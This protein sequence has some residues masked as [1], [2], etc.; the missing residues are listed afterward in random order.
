MSKIVSCCVSHT[1][2]RN[3]DGAANKV[4]L[5]VGQSNGVFSLYDLDSLQS[6][7]SFQISTNKIDSIAIN[8]QADWVAMGSKEQG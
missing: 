4:I 3:S 6:I 5:V 2:G 8:A 1:H 7:H